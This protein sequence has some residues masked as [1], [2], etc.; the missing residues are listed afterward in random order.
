MSQHLLP[1]GGG[2]T[3]TL[4]LLILARGP[5]ANA[6]LVLV[7]EEEA[8]QSL[9]AAAELH[10]LGPHLHG[11]HT[12]LHCSE[13][14]REGRRQLDSCQVSCCDSKQR[15]ADKQCADMTCFNSRYHNIP[16]ALRR[17]KQRLIK[18]RKHDGAASEMRVTAVKALPRQMGRGDRR[19]QSESRHCGVNVSP[20]L[21]GWPAGCCF[22]TTQQDS[23]G[24]RAH[25][26]RSVLFTT[27]KVSWYATEPESHSGTQLIWR[28][29]NRK[30]RKKVEI[31]VHLLFESCVRF[32][33]CT[34][35]AMK[36]PKQ[37][38]K[39][40]LIRESRSFFGC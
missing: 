27:S 9:G 32:K 23:T 4:G 3:L 21:N 6:G 29:G 20:R 22:S 36:W 34:Y 1:V 13:R 17:R 16:S 40:L 30:E 18:R 37:M 38:E 35:F 10:H 12:F 2:A 31:F 8:H 24:P 11:A 15:A 7:Q 19:Q 28:A 5:P 39:D 14:T 33:L 26:A 25:R